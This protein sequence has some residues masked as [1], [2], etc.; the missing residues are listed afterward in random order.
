M[1]MKSVVFA[2]VFEIIKI[3]GDSSFTQISTRNVTSHKGG[4]MTP[5]HSS[6]ILKIRF[7]ND[8]GAQI[9][10]MSSKLS[11]ICEPQHSTF[12]YATG[13]ASCGNAVFRL[14]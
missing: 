7:C 6:Q 12:P 10:A 4:L 13:R 2:M 9:S 1:S 5:V 11:K 8:R 3:V 14:L